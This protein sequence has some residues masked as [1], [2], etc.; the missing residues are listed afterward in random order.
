MARISK[1]QIDADMSD[2]FGELQKSKPK[3]AAHADQ[4]NITTETITLTGE[5]AREF[6]KN[7]EKTL[8]DLSSVN[9]NNSPTDPL[10][11]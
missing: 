4:S 7:P 10:F 3:T 8:L 6:L 1:E 9:A 2:W 11:G 5:K